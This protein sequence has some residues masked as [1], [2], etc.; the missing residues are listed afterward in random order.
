MNKR[1]LQFITAENISQSQFAD[2][3]GVARAS[4]S[5]IIAGRNKPGFDFVEKMARAF[6][7]LNIEW[8]ITGRGK[9]YKSALGE[10]PQKP[11]TND[12]YANDLFG[13]AYR[14]SLIATTVVQ[15]GN[16]LLDSAF[17]DSISPSD[18]AD[19][20]AA[21]PPA[22]PAAPAAS[23][24]SPTPQPTAPA[25]PGRPSGRNYAANQQNPAR[26]TNNSGNLSQSYNAPFGHPGHSI[27]KIIVFYDDG[28]YQELK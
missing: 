25:S 18:A 26:Q 21:V 10:Q 12:D 22:A 19:G 9:M 8:L 20:S 4:V 15:N 27:A 28:T 1:L 14:D 13:D 5:H 23:A 11:S 7:A 24:P 6:P 17:M 16:D 2:N 3:I